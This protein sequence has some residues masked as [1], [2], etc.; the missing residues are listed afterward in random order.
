MRCFR[1]AIVAA[2]VLAVCLLAG[3][4]YENDPREN[5]VFDKDVIVHVTLAATGAKKDVNLKGLPAFESKG[6]L[7]V[8][9]HHIVLKADLKDFQ[10]KTQKYAF[11]FISNDADGNW[12]LLTRLANVAE[13]PV[14]RDETSFK[15]MH[16]GWIENTAEDGYRNFWAEEAGMSK[17]KSVKHMDGGTIVIME[18]GAGPKSQTPPR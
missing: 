3:W 4:T 1:L 5:K 17:R 16:H 15:D 2:A 14:W 18:S 8:R 11:N 10:P 7:A 13:L 12:N 9:L 6:G